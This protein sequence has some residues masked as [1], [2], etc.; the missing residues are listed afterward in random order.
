MAGEQ[1]A[2]ATAE[3][4]LARARQ[5]GSPT[6]IAYC[7][8]TTAML[9]EEQD[10][11]HALSLLDESQRSGEAA[12][13]TFAVITAS[14]VRSRLLA[15]AGDYGT[16]AAVSLEVA[17]EAFR[18]G[19]REQQANALFFVAASLSAQRHHEPAAVVLGWMQS[20]LGPGDSVANMSLSDVA[21]GALARLPEHLGDARYASLYA[22]G[23][24]MTAEQILEYAHEQTEHSPAPAP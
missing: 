13:N 12:A 18:Y 6:A 3:E 8:F 19:R 20:V 5:C 10:P 9:C 16:A 4:S 7:C 11:G 14:M 1:A 2:L 15:R 24:V 21:L 17:R 22:E 23:A